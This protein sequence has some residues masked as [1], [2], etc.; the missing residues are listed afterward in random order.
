MAVVGRVLTFHGLILEK[1]IKKVHHY[2]ERFIPKSFPPGG[3]LY[4]RVPVPFF[5]QSNSVSVAIQTAGGKA[6]LVG[7]LET[8]LKNINYQELSGIG[9]FCDADAQAAKEKYK[10][11]LKG[12]H[13]MIC[14]YNLIF[15]DEPGQVSDNKPNTGVFIFPD[16]QNEGNLENVLLECAATCYP[17]LL[18]SAFNYVE[19]ADQKYMIDWTK[20]SKPKAVV[21]CI[22]NI[23]KPGRANQVSIQDN[24]WICPDT[25]NKKDSVSQLNQFIT[26]FIL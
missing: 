16:N 13:D 24:E 8:N 4:A 20:S 11:L 10:S 5:Y 2:W 19:T 1:Q 3:D 21:G 15:T 23:L 7:S 18:T 12:L 6:G 22:A 14:L 9:I 26:K 17:D 25:I